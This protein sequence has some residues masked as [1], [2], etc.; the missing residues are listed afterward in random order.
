MAQLPFSLDEL[1]D[2]DLPISMQQ[3][4]GMKV[5]GLIAQE[6]QKGTSTRLLSSLLFEWET[7]SYIYFH[8][9]SVLPEV[10]HEDEDGYL[11]VDYVEIIPVLIEAFNEH[12]EEYHQQQRKFEGKKIREHLTAKKMSYIRYFS[13][14]TTTGEFDMWKQRI[15]RIESDS[16]SKSARSSDIAPTDSE[17]SLDGSE[18]EDEHFVQSRQQPPPPPKKKHN[19]TKTHTRITDLSPCICFV[20]LFRI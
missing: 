14:L 20:C 9:I 17:D 11:S 12:L 7:N 3:D 10:V 13:F 5:I 2:M 16:E 18:S 6:V 8:Q 1:G 4:S 19:K 15:L